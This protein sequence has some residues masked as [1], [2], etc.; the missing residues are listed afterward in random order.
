VTSVEAANV[1]ATDILA[2]LYRIRLAD[3]LRPDDPLN[4]DPLIDCLT[5]NVF[6]NVGLH[7]QSDWVGQTSFCTRHS[8]TYAD[9]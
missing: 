5:G 4:F 3:V 9:T 8:Q 6:F 7:V 1:V 2:C